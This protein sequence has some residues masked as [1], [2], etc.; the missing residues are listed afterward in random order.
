M[1][2][3]MYGSVPVSTLRCLAFTRGYT[4]TT[5]Q[6]C[7]YESLCEYSTYSNIQR[8]SVIS[9]LQFMHLLVLYKGETWL[10]YKK[11]NHVIYAMTFGLIDDT[12]PQHR[13]QRLIP[14]QLCTWSRCQGNFLKQKLL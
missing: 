12:S 4:P 10:A 6:P 14:L 9:T 1:V 7:T 8:I 13:K 11:A 3:L 2:F 5:C